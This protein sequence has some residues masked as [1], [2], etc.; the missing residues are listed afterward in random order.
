MKAQLQNV[1]LIYDTQNFEQLY[2]KNSNFIKVSNAYFTQKYDG[3]FSQNKREGR[4]LTLKIHRV[5]LQSHGM[6]HI[7]FIIHQ[8]HTYIS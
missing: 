5:N 7:P 6:P 3:Y 8:L 1:T 4:E 2:I